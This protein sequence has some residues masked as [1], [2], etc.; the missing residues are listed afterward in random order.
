M[1]M[2][3]LL[4]TMWWWLLMLLL[5]LLLLFLLLLLL[6]LLML[7][8]LPLKT[9]STSSPL[10]VEVYN[11]CVD[12]VATRKMECRFFHFFVPTSGSYPAPMFKRW[13]SREGIGKSEVGSRSRKSEVGLRRGSESRKSH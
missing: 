1:L 7:L 2:L 4:L 10:V 12:V 5:L 6:L 8:L 13:L 3:L 9:S 11:F